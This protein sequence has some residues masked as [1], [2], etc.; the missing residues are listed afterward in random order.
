MATAEWKAIP[1]LAQ[2][3]WLAKHSWVSQCRVGYL[4]VPFRMVLDHTHFQILGCVTLIFHET[5]TVISNGLHM[6]LQRLGSGQQES[7]Q[8]YI[9]EQ[10]RPRTMGSE[11]SY[12]TPHALLHGLP[13]HSASAVGC[14]Q[15]LKQEYPLCRALQCAAYLHPPPEMSPTSQ[16]QGTGSGP[17]P[18]EHRW[19]PGTRVCTLGM[20]A[21]VLA[22]QAQCQEGSL[23]RQNTQK[24]RKCK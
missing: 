14:S 17:Q 18:Q 3:I 9:W 16:P 5:L 13:A 11:C 19:S 6:L 15:L 24:R 22:W 8:G 12:L 4:R 1:S 21:H 7:W 23:W 2:Q 20:H 10:Q